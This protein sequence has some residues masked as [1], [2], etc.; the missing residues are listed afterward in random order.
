MAR[1]VD[2][3]ERKTLLEARRDL[4][5]ARSAHAYVRGS[6]ERFYEWLASPAVGNLPAGPPVWICGDCHVGNLGPVGR[7]EGAAVVELRDL[8]Q[9]TI[10]NPAFDVV[11]LALSLAMAARGSDLPGVTT[12]HM[13]EELVAGYEAAFAGDKPT[14]AVDELPPPIKLVMKRALKRTWKHLFDERRGDVGRELEPGKRFWPL[15]DDERAG[16]QALVETE[17]V[18]RLVTQLECRDEAAEVALV[19]AA[20]WVKGCSSLGLLRAAALLKVTRAAKKKEPARSVLSLIDIKEAVAALTPGE[21]NAGVPR[22]EG[23]R[24]VAGARRLAPALGER[25]AAGTVVGKDVFVR[26]LL[27]QDLKVELDEISSDDGRAVARHLGMVVGRAHSRQ[28]DGDARRR[29]AAEM[30]AHRTKNIDAPT[31]L[32]QSVVDLVAIHERAYLEHCRRYALNASRAKLEATA[33]ADA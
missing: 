16:V 15:T 17:T 12:A 6:T 31:W 1:T 32:W 9:T 28:L 7:S 10:G 19:D 14:E 18:R 2:L 27:P 3:R 23:E 5:M 11:R 29:W 26:E 21:R 24:V 13:T 20:Y 22:H 4:K 33:D 30:A 8:D 25:M